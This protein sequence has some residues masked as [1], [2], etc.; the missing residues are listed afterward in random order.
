[1][2]ALMV[3]AT[4]DRFLSKVYGPKEKRP[5]PMVACSGLDQRLDVLIDE[6]RGLRAATEN[7]VALQAENLRLKVAGPSGVNTMDA[8]PPLHQIYQGL[9]PFAEPAPAAGVD[10]EREAEA[11]E[12]IAQADAMQAATAAEVNASLRRIEDEAEPDSVAG[13]LGRAIKRRVKG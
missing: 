9:E 12:R 5:V 2:N 11:G 7:L 4:V 1:M 3:L 10:P 6:V 13:R 8:I